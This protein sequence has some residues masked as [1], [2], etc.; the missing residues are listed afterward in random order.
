M[1]LKMIYQVIQNRVTRSGSKSSTVIKE[2][3]RHKEAVG[4][5]K[6]LLNGALDMIMHHDYFDAHDFEVDLEDFK[7]ILFDEY[8]GTILQLHYVLKEIE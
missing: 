5:Q 6:Q 7:V 4:Q 1:A 3:T 2:V 8:G